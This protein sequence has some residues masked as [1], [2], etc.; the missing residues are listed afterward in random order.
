MFGKSKKKSILADILTFLLLTVILIIFLY[1]LDENVFTLLAETRIAMIVMLLLFCCLQIMMESFRYKLAYAG[2]KIAVSF[3]DAINLAC[4]ENFGKVAVITGGALPIQ[5]YYLYKKGVIPGQSLG[6]GAAMYIIRKISLM[7][8]AAVVLCVHWGWFSDTVPGAS[9][10]MIFSYCICTVVIVILLLLST[11]K[12]ICNFACRMI[13]KLPSKG[14]WPNRKEKLT[15]QIEAIYSEAQLL[16]RM[17]R[18]AAVVLLLN[19]VELFLHYCIPWAVIRLMDIP[20]QTFS[21]VQ[22]L[23][24][25]MYL[26]AN[27]LPHIAGMGGVEFSF[28]TVFSEKFGAYTTTAMIYYRCATCYFPFILSFLKILAIKNKSSKE[29]SRRQS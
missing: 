13:E 2:K 8:Y 3:T 24:A 10:Y 7:L 26:F 5:S 25:A 16:F 27:A 18:K 9:G 21:D 20:G 11:S 23:S 15:L 6:M 14:K 4:M 12:Q 1:Y 19:M 17:K 22:T 28:L 29:R